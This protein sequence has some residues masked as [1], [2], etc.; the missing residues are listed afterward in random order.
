MPTLP[1]GRTL[2]FTSFDRKLD[3]GSEA[4]DLSQ[5]AF[6]DAYG[7]VGI[8]CALMAADHSCP[9]KH[10]VWPSASQ[11]RAHLDAMGLTRF[12]AEVSGAATDAGRTVGHFPEVVVP[13][14]FVTDSSVAEQISHLLW[15]QVRGS[16]DPSVL[17]ALTEGLWELIANALEHSGEHA[18]L[19]GQVY[20]GGEAPDHDDRVQVV[21]GDVGRGIRQSLAST[22]ARGSL[23]DREA[24][25]MAL[26]YLVSSVEDPG[27]GQGL[28]TTLEE[29]TALNGK[30]GV[31]SGVAKL[32]ADSSQRKAESV[33]WLPGTIVG[34]SL[35]LY[36]A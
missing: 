11:R 19:M 17:Q 15:A 31:R 30:L 3:E 23:N 13:L 22:P 9:E 4:C 29:V 28:T 1:R 5:L 10:L 26:E 18:V 16:V 25:E 33:P 32:T 20:R 35:P 2:T 6:V 7:L 27:R 14:T 24:I 36:P 34:M 8:A 21:I 12:L